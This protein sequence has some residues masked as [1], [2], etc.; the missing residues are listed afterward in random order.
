MLSIFFCF[1]MEKEFYVQIKNETQRVTDFEEQ[2]KINRLSVV[3]YPLGKGE[4][5][6]NVLKIL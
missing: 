6:P 5:R 1:L 4:A 3:N 2:L